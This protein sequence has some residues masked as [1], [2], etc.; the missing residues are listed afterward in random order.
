M[1]SAG[2]IAFDYR[3][4][5]LLAAAVGVVLVTALVVVLL[6]G[7]PLWLKIAATVVAVVYAGFALRRFL[8]N[9][10]RRL[11]WHDAGHWRLVC[12]AEEHTAELTGA[13]ARGAWIV[14]NLRRNDGIRASAVLGPDNCHED[15]RRRLR[16]RLAR[17]AADI[18]AAA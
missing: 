12:G 5:R 11:A 17:A 1:K 10:L 18:Q 6:S 16:V 4:S 9:P 14:L 3:P 13:T 15:I 8:D 7:L 2:V